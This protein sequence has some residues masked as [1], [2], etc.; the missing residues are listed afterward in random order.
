MSEA[1]GGPRS[2]AQ[3][4][5]DAGASPARQRRRGGQEAPTPPDR[6]P[7]VT[8]VF[9]TEKPPAPTTAAVE[10]DPMDG[11]PT[12]FVDVESAEAAE[13]WDRRR[14]RRLGS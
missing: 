12:K 14:W 10:L 7:K 13:H 11:S 3:A 6:G 5:D 1:V 9:V 4:P 2:R 8:L